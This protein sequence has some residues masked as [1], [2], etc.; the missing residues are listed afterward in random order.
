[1]LWKVR[2][3]GKPF[4]EYYVDTV[5][6]RIGK[7][8][9]HPTLG[10]TRSDANRFLKTAEIEFDF[11]KKEGLNRQSVFVDYGC[12][13]V[14]L[15]RVLIPYLASGHYHGVDMTD[16]FY[17]LGI[18]EFDQQLIQ[19]KKPYLAV[20]N[21]NTIAELSKKHIDFIFSSAVL[22]HIPEKEIKNYFAN[23]IALMDEGTIAYVDFTDA[24]ERKQLSKMT[25]LYPASFMLDQ[26]SEF[27]VNASLLT[28]EN[29]KD[30]KYYPEKHT[31]LKLRKQRKS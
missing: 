29:P 8:N 9:G 14:R 20:I 31:I 21:K 17:K 11:L 7:E 4:H 26:L 3:P 12:G 1:M 28:F 19:E 22:Y 6:K 27:D 18:D 24:P 23:I 25:W 2:H 10:K 16:T 5:K 30:A 13:S 15:G